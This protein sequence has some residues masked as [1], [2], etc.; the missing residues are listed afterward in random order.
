MIERM[1]LRNRAPFEYIEL[2]FAQKD[3]TILSAV[4][5]GGKTTILSQIA[6]AWYEIVRKAYPGEFEGKENKFYRYVSPAFNLVG[7]KPA[8]VFI[9]FRFGDEKID[10]LEIH[11]SVNQEEYAQLIPSECGITFEKV[12]YSVE[13][14]GAVKYCSELDEKKMKKVFRNNLLTYFPS[15]RYEQPGFLNNPFKVILNFGLESG[16]SN[17]LLNPIE[18]ITNLPTLANW[19]MDVVLDQS[20]GGRNSLDY[21][22]FDNIN[23]VFSETLSVKSGKS[24]HIGI[25]QRNMG[26]TRI[27]IGE[28]NS[29]GE[30]TKTLYPSIFN[31]SSGENALIC[32]FGEIVRQYDRI[33]PNI[34]IQNATG[35][36]L[37]DEIDKHLHVRMQKEVI[38]KLMKLFPRIQFIITS[39]SPFVAMG[40]DEVSGIGSRTQIVD[41]DNHSS[42]VELSD[43]RVFAEGYNAMI[44]KND[45]FKRLYDKLKSKTTSEKLQIVSEGDNFKHIKK[46]IEVLDDTLLDKIDFCDSDKTGWQQLKNAY[47][48]INKSNPQAPYLFIFDCDSGD[49]VN[50]LIENDKFLCFKFEQ[51]LENTKI[52]KGIENLYPIDIIEE[53]HYSK[54]TEVSD[55]GE[56]KIIEV[57]DKNAFFDTVEKLTESHYFFKYQPLVGKIKAIVQAKA[58]ERGNEEDVTDE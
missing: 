28:R 2:D 55:Y 12:K 41:L 54:K 30:W 9:T 29:F 37:I 16:Y 13:S 23:A 34:S 31:M 35:I 3:I 58:I 38:P 6:D 11:G 8:L 4:N 15:Y 33:H 53:Y 32:L 18:V 50:R 25:G 1:V 22:L 49:S 10:Y 39:H 42:V 7:S 52:N 43:T 56:R 36:V 5:G 19:M 47:D 40:F 27:Q 21:N 17:Q 48:A 44:E 57:F 51:N 26:A 45:Q 14:Q 24:L 20:M 46:A